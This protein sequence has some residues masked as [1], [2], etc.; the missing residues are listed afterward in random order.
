M[1]TWNVEGADGHQGVRELRSIMK[2][3]SMRILLLQET[4]HT[5]S[6][7]ERLEGGHLF[8][9]S[10]SDA[11]SKTYDGVAFIVAPSMAKS[12]PSFK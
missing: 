10:G 8:I 5:H 11:P 7:Y 3:R 9:N 1:G 2:A 6:H 12:L 4:H